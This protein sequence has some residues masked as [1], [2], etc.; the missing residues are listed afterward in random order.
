[1]QCLMWKGS[2]PNLLRALPICLDQ[3]KEA[4][5]YLARILQRVL[6]GHPL[7]YPNASAQFEQPVAAMVI[8]CASVVWS[9]IKLQYA[10]RAPVDDEKIRLTSYTFAG[11]SGDSASALGEE[12]HLRRIKLACNSDFALRAEAQMLPDVALARRHEVPL[13]GA[14][15]FVRLPNGEGQEVAQRRG[16]NGVLPSRS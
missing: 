3:L 6:R 1:M 12:Q 8:R 15:L 4:A 2:R 9:A 14:R 13:V 11:R 16:L 10:R 5:H 7:N